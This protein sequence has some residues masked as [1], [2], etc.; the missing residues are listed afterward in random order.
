MGC[1]FCFP[2]KFKHAIEKVQAGS[3]SP[4]NLRAR[5]T[6]RE[7]LIVCV[8]VILGFVQ[9]CGDQ[10]LYLINFVDELCIQKNFNSFLMRGVPY[11]TTTQSPRGPMQ[12][13]VL[14]FCSAFFPK[15][16]PG[17]KHVAQLMKIKLTKLQ[18]K[19]DF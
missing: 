12:G 18:K 1:D 4:S 16:L 19:G 13:Q 10:Q 14:H 2:L 17:V 8:S 6:N 3:Y 7:H 15:A 5:V 11:T 9:L